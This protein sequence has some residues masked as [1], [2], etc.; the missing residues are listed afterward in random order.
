MGVRLMF[1]IHECS[2]LALD[3]GL[4]VWLL[5]QASNMLRFCAENH[6]VPARVRPLKMYTVKWHT[7]VGL[8]IA[9]G[10]IARQRV[11]LPPFAELF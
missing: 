5:A 3:A 8:A 6:K 1:Q 7:A 2:L 10:L 11:P 4:N 9:F